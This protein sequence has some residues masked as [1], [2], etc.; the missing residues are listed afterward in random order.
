MNPIGY[1]PYTSLVKRGTRISLRGKGNNLGV[2]VVDTGK[3]LADRIV[4]PRVLL[5]KNSH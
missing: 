3:M 4:S 2:R 5:I 1:R